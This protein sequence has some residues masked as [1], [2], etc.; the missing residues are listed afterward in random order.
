MATMATIF[1]TQSA[2]CLLGRHRARRVPV[3]EGATQ[4]TCLDCGCDLIRTAASR[5]WFYSGTLA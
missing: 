5:Q 4:T 2:A 1:P 3:R